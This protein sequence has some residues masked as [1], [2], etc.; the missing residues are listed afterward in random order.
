MEAI[1]AC[2]AIV[3]IVWGVLYAAVNKARHERDYAGL[4]TQYVA[5]SDRVR[6]LEQRGAVRSHIDRRKEEL[7]TAAQQQERNA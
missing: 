7:R 6:H 3:L 1:T 5:L 4:Y 2:A